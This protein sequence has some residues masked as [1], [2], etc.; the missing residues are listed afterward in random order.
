MDWRTDLRVVR[1]SKL[2]NEVAVK[3]RKKLKERKQGWTA[4]QVH[5]IIVK[6]GKVHFHQIYIYSLLHRW[7]F[8]LKMQRN[9]S[10][11]AASK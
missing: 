11:N 9:V 1:P 6:E 7:G 5:E 2:P 10:A 3:V 8:K 4:Q